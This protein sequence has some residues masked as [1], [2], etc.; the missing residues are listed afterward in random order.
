MDSLESLILEAF[1]QAL[2]Q[3][4][5]PLP[6]RIQSQLQA[7]GANLETQ[8]AQL[9]SLAKTHGPLKVAYEAQLDML[10]NQGGERKKRLTETN[11]TNATDS[12]V[13]RLGKLILGSDNPV[14]A[15]KDILLYAPQVP[16]SA[17]A[18]TNG[19]PSIPIPKVE[20]EQTRSSAPAPKVPP[21]QIRSATQP[22]PAP[23]PS[24]SPYKGMQRFALDIHATGDDR[25]AYDHYI[26]ELKRLNP[27]WLIVPD[28]PRADEADA[29]LAIPQ[30]Q[31]TKVRHAA[32]IATRYIH[33]LARELTS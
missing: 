27:N 2:T 30:D 33:D 18:P 23:E 7:I 6:L 5:E 17:P 9:A 12:R 11:G 14:L 28:L 4:E 10:L 8:V 13:G 3:Q 19:N 20:P 32:Y 29:Y 1:L 16:D 26:T 24:K 25:Q 15:S 21:A 31:N 22:N